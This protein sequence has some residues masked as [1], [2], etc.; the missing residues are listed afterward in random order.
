MEIYMYVIVVDEPCKC[1]GCKG[2]VALRDRCQ[3]LR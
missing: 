3:T 1:C 2:L